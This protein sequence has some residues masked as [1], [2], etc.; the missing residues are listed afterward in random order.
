MKP[1]F[2]LSR[3]R[4]LAALNFSA[5]LAGIAGARSPIP[6]DLT[7]RLD[8]IMTKAVPAHG[9]GAS[10][11]VTLDGEVLLRKGYGLADCELEVPMDPR[12][13]F[14]IGSLTKQF[15]AVAI[16]QLVQAGKIALADDIRIYVPNTPTNGHKVTLYELLTHTSGIP[17]YTSQPEWE[18]L[19]RQDMTV[20]EIL[21]LV[22]GKPLDF[23]PGLS[24]KYSNT[25]YI[26]LGAVIEKVS[27]LSYANYVEQH[28]LL[29][30]GMNS[31]SYDQTARLIAHR[32]PGY[33]YRRPRWINAPFLSMTQPFAAGGLLSSVDDM[34]RWEQALAAGKLVNPTLLQLAYT[35]AHL[36]DGHSTGYGFGRFLG[37]LDSHATIEHGG[38]IPG[39]STYELR[40]PDANLYVVVFENSLG[41]M[42]GPPSE[43]AQQLGRLVLGAASPGATAEIISN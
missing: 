37:H 16:L 38:G 39:F 27:G 34:W 35:P 40:V 30:A 20:P 4:L 11:L 43:L 23:L 26:L 9:P 13:I 25:G 7:G 15:T 14:R 31:S 10:V 8:A 24:W 19:M 1:F 32:I 42:S 22:K 2:L 41:G 17:D 33:V 36:P 21:G 6:A 3:F 12:D 5:G 18:K 29:P 28:L